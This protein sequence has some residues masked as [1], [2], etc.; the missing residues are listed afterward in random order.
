MNP[1]AREPEKRSSVVRDSA[2]VHA[3]EARLTQALK[4]ADNDGCQPDFI[5]V[6]PCTYRLLR[7]HESAARF[8]MCTGYGRLE[9][10]GF[11]VI[12][13]VIPCPEPGS[14]PADDRFFLAYAVNL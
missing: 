9:V 5:V 8:V 14:R 6:H 3:F 4:A 13:G 10:H 12:E 1:H 11:P 7:V 2:K